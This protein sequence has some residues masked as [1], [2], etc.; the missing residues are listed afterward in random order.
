MHDR[1]GKSVRRFLRQIVLRSHLINS[2][3][4]SATI[5]FP[6]ERR[7]LRVLWSRSGVWLEL[8]TGTETRVVSKAAGAADLLAG[9]VV[10]PRVDF[11]SPAIQVPNK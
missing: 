8:L 3:P 10:A 5:Q 2:L 4:K 11:P 1:F 7:A 9:C 6:L